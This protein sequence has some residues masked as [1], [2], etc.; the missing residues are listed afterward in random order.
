MDICGKKQIL[1]NI[2]QE[3]PFDFVIFNI[4]IFLFTVEC[5]EPTG[6]VLLGQFFTRIFFY[7]LW[8]EVAIRISAQLG[9]GEKLILLRGSEDMTQS[10]SVVILHSNACTSVY[11]VYPFCS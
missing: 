11:T 10:I 3:V 1:Q 9:Q 4:Y 5:N 2:C 6:Q 8:I 7:V